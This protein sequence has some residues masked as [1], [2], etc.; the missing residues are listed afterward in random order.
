M[1]RRRFLPSL[2]VAAVLGAA[3]AMADPLTDGLAA[4]QQ[5]QWT[6][7]LIHFRQAQAANL[8]T[9]RAAFGAVACLGKLG[10]HAEA[11]AEARAMLRRAPGSVSRA[12]ALAQVQFEAADDAGARQTYDAALR[13][14]PS[15]GGL[16][17]GAAWF[18][19]TTPSAAARDPG[20]AVRLATF[21]CE[22]S[23][24][25]SADRLDTLAA[26]Q[27]AAGDFPRAVET[28]RRAVALAADDKRMDDE[29]RARLRERLGLYGARVPW[30]ERPKP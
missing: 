19:A 4:Y 6:V 24:W 17:N 22:R 9:D 23:G 20:R 29:V 11:I 12:H 18:L 10:R 5:K 30:R 3:P 27:A 14:H 26:A 7:A 21:A 1:F 15:D 28:Q 16:A 13:L 8:G 25:K 2:V